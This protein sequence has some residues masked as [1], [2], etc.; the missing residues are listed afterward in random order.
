V[1]DEDPG[2][3]EEFVRRFQRTIAGTVFKT[4]RSYGPVDKFLLEDLVQDA[5][6]RLCADNCRAVREFQ[7]ADEVC[8]YGLLRATA[9]SAVHDHFRRVQTI[10]RGGDV[11]PLPIDSI[12]RE[13]LSGDEEERR[14]HDALTLDR[15]DQILSQGDP[16]NAARNRLV[17]WLYHRDGFSASEIARLPTV[18][19]TQK[20]VETLL[21]R[22][23][24]NLQQ[25]GL[26]AGKGV[27]S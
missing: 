13:N 7:A 21:R 22:L 10:K 3:W 5:F 23:R 27:D 12:L 17:F 20:G 19:L 25:L 14:H 18:G 6:V 1:E 9:I 4:A 26:A 24:I 11:G 16:A 15:I 8:F 2:A